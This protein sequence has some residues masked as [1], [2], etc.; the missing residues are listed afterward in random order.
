MGDPGG[1]P[2]RAAPNYPLAER[3]DTPTEGFRS[4]D[5]ELAAGMVPPMHRDQVLDGDPGVDLRRSDRGVTEDELD[6]PNVGATLEEVRGAGVPQDVGRDALGDAGGLGAL[7][8]DE[9]ERLDPEPTAGH[10]R[11]K[12]CRLLVPSDQRRP[13]FTEVA[14]QSDERVR[15][16]GQDAVPSPFA[17]PDQ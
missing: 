12:E 10:R 3:K 13:G 6:V 2:A 17:L 14:A 1:H 4:R 11:E 8:D 5:L 7:P 16:D 9:V 15:T